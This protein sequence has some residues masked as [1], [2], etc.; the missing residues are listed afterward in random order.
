MLPQTLI[1]FVIKNIA[2]VGLYLFQQKSLKVSQNPN[3]SHSQQI[4]ENQGFYIQWL[5]PKLWYELVYKLIY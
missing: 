3:C 1:N 5:Y 2:G 4:R